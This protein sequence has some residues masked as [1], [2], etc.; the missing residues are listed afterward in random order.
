MTHRTATDH[1]LVVVLKLC[2]TLIPEVLLH[3]RGVESG[4]VEATLLLFEL[5]RMLSA[6]GFTFCL[7][8]AS[9]SLL[10]LTTTS[11]ESCDT[12]RHWSCQYCHVIFVL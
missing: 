1:V 12:M 4:G 6:I 9:K 11:K 3:T 5:C 2:T 7:S 8:L 10:G